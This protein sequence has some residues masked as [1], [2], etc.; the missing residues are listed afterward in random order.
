MW[1]NNQYHGVTI[2]W[3]L[4]EHRNSEQ[5][6]GDS[7]TCDEV[8]LF[9][10]PTCQRNF[11]FAGLTLRHAHI[12]T[13][14]ALCRFSDC[15]GLFCVRS[16]F[17]KYRN[18]PLIKHKWKPSCV[19]CWFNMS[20]MLLP[21][22]CSSSMIFWTIHFDGPFNSTHTFTLKKSF[23]PNKL[24]NSL[25]PPVTPSWTQWPWSL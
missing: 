12:Y 4:W 13:H 20:I 19:T 7:Q 10:T 3:E 22:T 24:V 1:R 14:T 21:V 5:S 11:L 8:G 15:L 6:C 16:V 9:C 2:S 23:T 17:L 25:I 18:S